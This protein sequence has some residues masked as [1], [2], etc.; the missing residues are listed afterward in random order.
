[1][2]VVVHTDNSITGDES[3]MV[4]IVSQVEMMLARYDDRVVRVLVHL[5]HE[6]GGR[7]SPNDVRCVLGALT[8]DQSGAV[9]TE[10]ADTVDAAARGTAVRLGRVIDSRWVEAT[11]TAAAGPS[12]GLNQ[13]LG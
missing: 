5:S 2:N 6:S 1:M 9:A 10:R 4:R 7:F 8:Q 12:V 13:P 11:T 3:M